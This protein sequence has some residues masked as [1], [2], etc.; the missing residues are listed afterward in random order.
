MPYKIKSIVLFYEILIKFTIAVKVLQYMYIYI[1]ISIY[2][3]IYILQSFSIQGN[4]RLF[5][6]I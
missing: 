5:E 2:I 1:Y 6:E 4:S 3:Y